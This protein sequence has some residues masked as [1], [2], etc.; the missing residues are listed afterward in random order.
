MKTLARRAAVTLALMT[1][2]FAIAAIF[3]VATGEDYREQS[4]IMLLCVIL[5]QIGLLYDKADEL[6]GDLT[7][8]VVECPYG[9]GKCEPNPA[10]LKPCGHEGSEATQPLPKVPARDEGRD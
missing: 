2:A 6:L 4:T 1:G 5:A 9:H 10:G 7:A 3:S 8:K